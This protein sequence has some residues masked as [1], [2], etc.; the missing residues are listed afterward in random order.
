MKFHHHS[1]GYS[2]SRDMTPFDYFV[3]V[4]GVI[5]FVLLFVFVL[6]GV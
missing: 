4:M 1:V 2:E 3:G 5:V 6:S